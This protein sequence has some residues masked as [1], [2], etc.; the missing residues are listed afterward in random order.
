MPLFLSSFP[1]FLFPLSFYAFCFYFSLFFSLIFCRVTHCVFQ[2]TAHVTPFSS[3]PL[4]IPLLLI[5][6]DFSFVFCFE[7]YFFLINSLSF[8]PF[9]F[10][11]FPSLSS[12]MNY[13]CLSNSS[14]HCEESLL[15][16]ANLVCF[17]SLK[18]LSAEVESDSD[19]HQPALHDWGLLF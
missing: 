13:L 1:S 8:I 5:F 10:P 6:S 11:S 18:H 3:F 17:L 2:H 9:H 16:E 14:I 15:L 12:G 7:E 4:F 19:E